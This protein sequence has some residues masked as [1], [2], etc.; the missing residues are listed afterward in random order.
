VPEGKRPR[1][2]QRAEDLRHRVVAAAAIGG[3]Q[4]RRQQVLGVA[5]ILADRDT[6]TEDLA[7][8]QQRVAGVG[9]QRLRPARV[10]AHVKHRRREVQLESSRVQVAHYELRLRVRAAALQHGLWDASGL[11][12]ACWPLGQRGGRRRGP[13]RDTDAAH[14]SER[15]RSCCRCVSPA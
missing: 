11:R 14:D 10:A 3:L 12:G 2:T 13:Q 1:P 15:R 5:L 7:V 9:L 6:A 8:P 4:Q